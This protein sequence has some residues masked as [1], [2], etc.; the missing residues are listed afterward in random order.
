MTGGRLWAALTIVLCIGVGCTDD[1]PRDRADEAV[2]E[3]FF[4]VTSE[5]SRIVE[6]ETATGTVRRTVVDLRPTDGGFVQIDAV[7][8]APDRRAIYYSIGTDMPKGSIWRVELPNG[9]PERIA[10]GISPSISPDGRRLAF[11]A[12]V[13][14]H[15][16]DLITGDDRA[17]PDAVG[18]LGGSDAAWSPD[19]RR[20]A[21]N[22]HAADA[23]GGTGM[24]DTDSAA[25]VDLQPAVPDPT[26]I[27]AAYSARYRPFDG[28][29]A[30]VCCQH[31][32]LPED[33]P[34][35]GR[36]LVFH[37]PAT[38]AEKQS[39]DL[40]IRAGRIAFDATGRHTLIS[41][42]PDG[43]VYRHHQGTFTRVPDLS[44]VDAIDW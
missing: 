6:V 20:V 25:T 26:R 31:P 16:R 5:W 19:G 13:V 28:L 18:E 24:L 17:F 21:F 34:S 12:G 10:D 32:N 37:D 9:R 3:T 35:H 27:Y 29:L 39:V 38:G 2:P 40:P 43:A 8:L 4:A 23:I 30:V 44:G 15:V 42:W 7:D 11:V 22:S 36:R 41:S 1:G 33:D 14:L